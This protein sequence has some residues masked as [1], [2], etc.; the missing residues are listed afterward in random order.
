MS[1]STVGT[2]R[3]PA[4]ARI[5]CA[6]RAIPINFWNQK[7]LTWQLF[8]TD[9]SWET[10]NWHSDCFL[11]PQEAKRTIL[12]ATAYCDS[13]SLTGVKNA[14]M[15]HRNEWFDVIDFYRLQPTLVG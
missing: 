10:S 2:P 6:S 1:T 9:D 13:D 15:S 11:C 8:C 3:P 12:L 7:R 14:M 4:G 5:Q